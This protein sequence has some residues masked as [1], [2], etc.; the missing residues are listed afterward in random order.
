MN[1][2]QEGEET[3]AQWMELQRVRKQR[4]SEWNFRESGDRYLVNGTLESEETERLS[5]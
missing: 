5:G 4:L 2:T 3:E 1:G